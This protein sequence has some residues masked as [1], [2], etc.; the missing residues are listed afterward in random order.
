MQ[1]MWSGVE[2]GSL[3][4]TIT[5]Q[6]LWKGILW[7][8]VCK[9]HCI[10]GI[11]AR[12][13]GSWVTCNAFYIEETHHSLSDRMTGHYFTTTVLNPYLPVFIHTQ[14]HQIPFQD[15]WSV[16]VIH[17]LPDSTP[18]H[19]P[20]Q[21]QIAYQL[22]IQSCHH[23]PGLNIVNPLFRPCSWRHLRFSI[24]LTYST[25]EEGHSVDKNLYFISCVSTF[26]WPPNDAIQLSGI[27]AAPSP[28]L[29]LSYA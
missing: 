18:D 12:R 29:Y 24:S 25:T 6:Q 17:N 4:M 2:S 26:I 23:T 14:S 28:L 27:S 8:C 22:V 5:D 13:L 9:T 3:F 21:F 7:D 20:R 1:R 15:C 16:I 11:G 10:R 19:I